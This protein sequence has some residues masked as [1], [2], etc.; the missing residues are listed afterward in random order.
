MIVVVVDFNRNGRSVVEEVLFLKDLCLS[1]LLCD[2]F[3]SDYFLWISICF[4]LLW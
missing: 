2:Y 1:K 4:V 3:S